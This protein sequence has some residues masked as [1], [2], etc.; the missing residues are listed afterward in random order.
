M[1]RT[2]AAFRVVI[3]RYL[4]GACTG[5]WQNISKLLHYLHSRSV[6]SNSAVVFLLLRNK[7]HCSSMDIWKLFGNQ[8]ILNKIKQYLNFCSLSWITYERHCQHFPHSAKKRLKI[9]FSTNRHLISSIKFCFIYF[10]CFPR[11]CFYNFLKLWFSSQCF[12]PPAKLLVRV[13]SD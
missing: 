2:F 4:H 1:S 12:G 11:W 10:S 9:Y 7:R 3:R 5:E 8:I 6:H 13:N